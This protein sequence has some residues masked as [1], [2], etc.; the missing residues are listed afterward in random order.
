VTINRHNDIE[1]ANKIISKIDIYQTTNELPES[2]NWEILKLFGFKDN[3]DF[4]SPEYT[5]IDANT[6][7]LVFVEGFDG[8]YLMWNSEERKWKI[9]NPTIVHHKGIT[10]VK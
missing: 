1:F 7:E 5:K 10:K 6:Y 3:K 9:G 4:L 8:P 2:N